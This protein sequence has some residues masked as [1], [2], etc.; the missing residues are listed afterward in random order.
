MPVVPPRQSSGRTLT[1]SQQSPGFLL[2]GSR[3]LSNISRINQLQTV[4]QSNI[5]YVILGDPA[6]PENLDFVTSTVAINTQ[7]VPITRECDLTTVDALWNYSCTSGFSGQYAT[8]PVTTSGS[9]LYVLQYFNNSAMTADAAVLAPTTSTF[10]FG[11][12]VAI[13]DEI[14]ASSTLYS[15]PDIIGIPGSVSGTLDGYV[16]ALKCTT[17][18]YDATYVWTNNSFQSFLALS[19]TNATTTSVLTESVTSLDAS[20]GGFTTTHVLDTFL[21]GFSN[22][23][24]Q[25]LAN[26]VAQEY[27]R[28]VI[29][30]PAGAFSLRGNEEEQIRSTILVTHL[31]LAPYYCLITFNCLYVIVGVIVAVIALDASVSEEGVREMQEQL[32]IWGL[33]AHGFQVP[34][35]EKQIQ[36]GQSFDGEAGGQENQARVVGIVEKETAKNGWRYQTWRM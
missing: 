31:P 19:S 11:L 10:Y 18:L 15:D 32:S 20:P 34:V 21:L 25:D 4:N 5:T 35:D 12:F 28:L 8:G 1:G 13:S 16:Y 7:C 17:N 3:T 2:E 24:A 14:N 22:D 23:T 6:V 26:Q 9:L 33:V 29:G 36:N 27:S 30:L